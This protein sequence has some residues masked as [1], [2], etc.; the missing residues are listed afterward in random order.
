MTQ[1]ERNSICNANRLTANRN[2]NHLTARSMLYPSTAF[3]VVNEE[4]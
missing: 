3:S 2:T 1:L 4:R